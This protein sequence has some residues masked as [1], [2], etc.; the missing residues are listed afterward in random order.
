MSYR[1]VSA[2]TVYIVCRGAGGA[3]IEMAAD[4][5]RCQVAAADLTRQECELIDYLIRSK[6]M[7]Q[8]SKPES[9]R[10]WPGRFTRLLMLILLD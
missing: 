8:S 5:E 4:D 3:N 7:I 1:P 6:D 9:R 2:A 10:R